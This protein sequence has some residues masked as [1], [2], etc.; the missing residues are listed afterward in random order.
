M[1]CRLFFV[2]IL[3]IYLNPGFATNGVWNCELGNEGEWSCVGDESTKK[4]TDKKPIQAKPAQTKP[5]VDEPAIVNP[6]A[7]E[8]DDVDTIKT[9]IDPLKPELAEPELVKP[10]PLPYPVKVYKK[11]NPDKLKTPTAAAEKAGWTCDS[12]QQSET[13]DCKLVGADPKGKAR[14]I[15]EEGYSTGFIA[16]TFNIEKEQVFKELRNKLKYDP[17]ESC[18]ASGRRLYQYAPVA[19]IR[20]EAPM[21]V[22]ADYTELYDKEVTSFFGNVLVSRADQQVTSDMASYDT[23]SQTMDAQG[24]VFYSEDGLA[25]TSDSAHMNLGTDE[26][27]LRNAL[28]MSSSAAIRGSA[29]VM[30]RDNRVLSRYKK[31][32]FTTCPPGNEDWVLHADRLKM[33][34]QTGQASVKSAWMEFKGLPVLYIPYIT[35]PIDDR[36]LSGFLPITLGT[37]SETGFDVTVPY[38]WNIAPNYDL[39][40]RPRF[41]TKRG[42]MIGGEFRYLTRMQSG[43]LGVEYLPFDILRQKP[44]YSGTFQNYMQFTENLQSMVDLNYVSDDQF[45]DELNNALGISNERHLKSQADLSYEIDGLS[46]LTRLEMYQTIDRDIARIDKPYQQFPQVSLNLD[47]SFEDFPVDLAMENEYVY[48]HRNDRVE[49]HR[50]NV[51]PSITVPI[52]TP[53]AF[54]KPKF[55]LQHTE[56]SLENQMPGKEDSIS[57]TLPIFSVDSGLFIESD[58]QIAG[59]DY[60]HTVEPRLFYLYIP[61]TGQQDIPDFDS[62]LYDV[63][64]NSLFRENRFSSVDRVQDTNQITVAMTS[65]LIDTE[66]GHENLNFSIGE[67]FYFKDR[68]VTLTGTKKTNTY[69][70][71]VAELSSQLTDQLSISSGVHWNPGKQDF[72]RGQGLIKYRNKG[73]QIVNLG[74]RYRK[75]NLNGEA[76]IIQ[77]DTSFKWPLYDDWYG[78]GRWQYSL[79]FNSTKE[80]FM[81]VEKESCCWR[82]RFIW[83][84]FANTLNDNTEDEMDEGVFIQFELKGLT[85]FGDKVDEFLEESLNGYQ[86]AE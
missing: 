78:I 21:D 7:I 18:L 69:S 85:S 30:Y 52:E 67:I 83:R 82:F 34:K 11:T 25:I 54:V 66:T 53:G 3:Y 84:R 59:D 38:Y 39:T 58:A 4:S 22:S 48:F 50:F 75:D 26:A 68:E 63:N 40:V 61:K 45:F 46:F 29:E 65:R 55:S 42:A 76:D 77:T 60:L 15:E 86:R 49:G 79:K 35:F 17:W 74:Y 62:S 9:D 81:G 8:P 13:W 16:P 27:R 12:N 14:M 36:R 19:N 70:D 57:R 2:F 33:N 23:V 80:S 64:F 28:F 5:V 32:A 72:T 1:L 24:Q 43:S 47:H 71:I 6:V 44:R 10:K 31:A 51:K 41:M 20:N 56:Y 37:N 73:E